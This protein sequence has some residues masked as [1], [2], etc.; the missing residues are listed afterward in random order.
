MP[1]YRLTLEYDGTSFS[2]WQVQPTRRTVAGE[3]SAALATLDGTAPRITA[4]GRTD[5][6]AHAHGQVA[7]VTLTRSWDPVRLRAAANSV[8]PDDV[9]VV[10]AAVEVDGFDA[11]RDAVD[12]VYK[13]VVVSRQVR[14]PV[15]QRYSWTVRGPL[16]TNAMRDAAGMLAGRRDFAALGG[17]THPQGDTVRT[18][19]E[20]SVER[21]L[22]PAGRGGPSIDALIITVRADAF[23]RGMMRA[24]AGALVKVGQRRATPAWLA[25]VLARTERRS[26][27]VTLAPARGLHQWAVTYGTRTVARTA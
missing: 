18:V 2:G 8:L 23:L 7:G 24:I 19:H 6:G 9:A 4:A 17:A 15:T 10:D 22:F 16:D 21:S 25:D 27:E 1:G 20:A 13:Y 3:L 14:A 12:R 26:A 11:R 5:A